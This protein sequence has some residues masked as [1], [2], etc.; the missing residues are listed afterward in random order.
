MALSGL[1]DLV[2]RRQTPCA[3]VALILPAYV[4]GEATLD[5]RSSQHVAHC[6]R[7]QAEIA[8]YRRMLRTLRDLREHTP[9]PPSTVL[10]DII[11]QLG[12]DDADSRTLLGTFVVVAL[13]AGAAGGAG[14]MLWL[15]R[16]SRASQ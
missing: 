16:R 14:M 4:A 6:L 10:A 2:R 3:E 12:G 5:A 7:C 15:S 9:A 1:T 8:H 11:G 13:A